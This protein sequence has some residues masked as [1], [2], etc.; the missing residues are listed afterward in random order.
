MSLN[1]SRGNAPPLPGTPP[2]SQYSNAMGFATQP[3]DR[4]PHFRLAAGEYDVSRSAPVARPVDDGAATSGDASPGPSPVILSGRALVAKY[5]TATWLYT[6][7]SS[8][9][10]DVA[11]RVLGLIRDALRHGMDTGGGSCSSATRCV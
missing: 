7:L 1:G 8:G 10:R 2:V 3:E 4:E 11:L 5:R 9:R 6:S